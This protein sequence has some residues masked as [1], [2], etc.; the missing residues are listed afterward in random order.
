MYGMET[1]ARSEDFNRAVADL[2]KAVG[3]SRRAERR[4]L[5]GNIPISSRTAKTKKDSSPRSSESGESSG[6][7]DRENR[8][9]DIHI[10]E[11]EESDNT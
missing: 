2:R 5:G 11:T 7:V 6:H 1:Y 8:E 10:I 9:T 3:I 4:L